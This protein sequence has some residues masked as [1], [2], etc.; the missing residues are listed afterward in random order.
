MSE[1]EAGA[2]ARRASLGTGRQRWFV[3]LTLGIS[4]VVCLVLANLAYSLGGLGSYV[5]EEDATV[6]GSGTVQRC[7]RNP[8]DLWLTWDCTVRITPNDG[9]PPGVVELS[10]SA[11]TQADVGKRVAMADTSEVR[12]ANIGTGW[13]KAEVTGYPYLGVIIWGGLIVL[14]IM[15]GLACLAVLFGIAAK[16]MGAKRMGGSRLG[17]LSRSDTRADRVRRIAV[18]ALV[19]VLG[20]YLAVLWYSLFIQERQQGGP[21]QGTARVVSC[22]RMPVTLWLGFEC[23]VDV[24]PRDGEPVRISTAY[25]RFTASEAG[26]DI[27]VTYTRYRGRAS[28]QWEHAEPQSFNPVALLPFAGFVFGPIAFHVL[29]R[30]PRAA[31]SAGPARRTPTD[32]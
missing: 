24:R 22:E 12:S 9:A 27:P 4:T 25:S 2:P 7:E 17:V 10:D 11:L 23:T 28:D 1:P 14:A 31:R 3:V 15:G 6:D 19:Y 16:R 29:V 21:V 5:T 32:S 18:L 13:R 26:R 30:K 20:F 8:A